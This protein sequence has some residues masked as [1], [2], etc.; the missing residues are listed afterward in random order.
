MKSIIIIL[1]LAASSTWLLLQNQNLKEELEIRRKITQMELINLLHV[2][3]EVASFTSIH[4]L[5]EVQG[6]EDMDVIYRIELLRDH[7]HL[8]TDR[9]SPDWIDNVAS[10]AKEEIQRLRYEQISDRNE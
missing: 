9:P 10:A 6:S 3:E 1:L 2:Q 4:P 8:G 7:L 5:D